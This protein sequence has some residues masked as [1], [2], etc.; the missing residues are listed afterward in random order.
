[1]AKLG[2]IIRKAL[3][4]APTED[5]Q[6]FMLFAG[7]SGAGK[8]SLIMKLSQHSDFLFDKRVAVIAVFPQKTTNSNDEYFTI[9][10]PFCASREIPYF[11]VKSSLDVTKLV[12]ELNQFD[13]V[14][15]DTPSLD[16]EQNNSFRDFWKVRQMLS[17]LAPLEV[18]YVVNAAMNR[19]YFRDSSA[20]HHPLQPDYV[21]ITHLD[22][23][24]KWGPVIPFLQQMGCSARYLSKGNSLSNSLN[25][26]NPQWF[27]QK[28][29]Q[30]N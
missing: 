9:L 5:P 7:P 19:F 2:G 4:D 23:V 30:E 3:G 14:F 16:I 29:L 18:H 10:K 27:A 17:P 1:M 25:E 13:H 28:V 26:F 22:E 6:K 12:D 15:I 21:A 24:T 8:T 20:T 11:E